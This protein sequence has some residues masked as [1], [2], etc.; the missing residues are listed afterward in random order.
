M[1]TRAC[2]LAGLCLIY[3]NKEGVQTNADEIARLKMI[4]SELDSKS[5]E[6]EKKVSDLNVTVENL[7]MNVS[8]QHRTVIGLVE[9]R[10]L[11]LS[12]C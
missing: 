12:I 6:D 11:L 3:R 7:H 10:K 2:V 9:D 8:L 4:A 5:Q 1:L